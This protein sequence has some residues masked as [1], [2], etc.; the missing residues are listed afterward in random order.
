[1]TKPNGVDREQQGSLSVFPSRQSAVAIESKKRK[2]ATAATREVEFEVLPDG[3]MVDLVKSIRQPSTLEFLVWHEGKIRLTPHIDHDGELLVVPKID[4]TVVSALRLPTTARSCPEVGELFMLLMNSIERYV[5][6]TTE[7]SFLVAAF[8]LTALFSDRLS[9]VPYLCIS[10]PLQ[11][12]KTRLLRLLHCLCRRAIHASAI[13]PAS[14]YRLAPLRATWLIDDFGKDQTSRDIQR[15]LRGGNRRGSLVVCNGKA[16]ENFGP[17]VI[18]SS[19]PLDDAALVSRTINIIMNPS[20][21]HLP[22]LDSDAERELSEALQPVLEMFRLLHYGKV[23][24]SQYPGVLKFPPGLRD[25]ARALAAPMM[26]NAELQGRLAGVLES[27]V[28][29]MEFDRFHEPEMVT[30]LALYSLCHIVNGDCYVGKVTEET[31]RILRENGETLFYKPKRVG[32]ILNKSL[33]FTTRRRGKGWRIELTL[34]IRR[35]IHSQ[36]K[37]MG[38][39]RSDIVPW[40]G[41]KYALADAC[42]LCSKFGMMIDHEGRRLKTLDDAL[43]E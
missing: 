32:Q 27:Q 38:I 12:G 36:A 23:V 30:M 21:R 33:G 35:K 34:A 43:H 5:D 15:L 2:T 8:V 41:V 6:I 26:G 40:A 18:V 22:S 28:D 39:K 42:T 4:P 29:P 3:R 16:F 37:A 1:M 7:Y 14:L 11:S 9:V 25:S 24:A 10:G 20:D 13:T 17:K 19:V 31:E